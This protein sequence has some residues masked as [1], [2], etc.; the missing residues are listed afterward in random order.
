M[1]KLLAMVLSSTMLM[2]ALTSCANEAG[3]TDAGANN[4][5]AGNSNSA[6]TDNNAVN[7]GDIVIGIMANTTGGAAQYGIAVSQGANFYIDQVNEAGGINGK[8]ISVVQYDDKGES[9]EVLMLFERMSDDGAMAIIGSV[10]TPTTLALSDA[11]YKAG[12]PQITASATSPSVTVMDDTGEVRTNVF[13]SCFIDS[14][15]GQKMADYASEKLQATAAAVIFENDD[16]AVGLKDAFVAQ[17]GELGI[18]VVAQE[19][20][21]SGDKAFQA[22]LTTIAGSNPDVIFMPNYYEDVGL[23]VTQARQLGIEA[24]FLGGD[25]WAGVKNFASAEDLEGS[26]FCSGFAGDE[27]FAADY[28][29]KYGENA[30]VGMFEALGHDAALILLNAIEE[31]EAEAVEYGTDEYKAAIIDAMKATKGLEGLTG[32]FEFDENNDPVKTASMMVL[33]AGE[34]VFSEQF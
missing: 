8:Q 32:S 22:Q 24:T 10:L 30:E 13:R 3:N 17:C 26:V 6:S 7:E 18:D 23:I 31:V 25:G 4:T 21:T 34:E 5:P 20:Y 2:G 14:F 11:T 27:D 15:Q 9:S 16:Y 1:K 28:K 12:M 19:G 33:T 29:A